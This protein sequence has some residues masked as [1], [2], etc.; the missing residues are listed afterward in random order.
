MNGG[1]HMLFLGWRI[2]GMLLRVWFII[3][4]AFAKTSFAVAVAIALRQN[5][6]NSICNEHRINKE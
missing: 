4:F 5:I 3:L 6:K 1:L 2:L